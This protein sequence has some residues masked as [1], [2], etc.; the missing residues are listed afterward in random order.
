[1]EIPWEEILQDDFQKGMFDMELEDLEGP[2]DQT[3]QVSY[4]PCSLRPLIN[5]LALDAEKETNY[6]LA[7]IEHGC[8]R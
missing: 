2:A 3:E 8:K 7:V 1:M 5:Y 6:Q 4:F